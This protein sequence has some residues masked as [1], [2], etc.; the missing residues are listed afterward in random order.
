[1]LRPAVL[2]QITNIRSAAV[3]HSPGS[4]EELVCFSWRD[5]DRS[6]RKAVGTL[7]GIC[8]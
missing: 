7:L 8:P 6:R 3:G 4:C 5:A 2:G 1:M